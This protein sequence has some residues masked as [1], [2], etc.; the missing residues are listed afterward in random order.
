[1]I[2]LEYLCVE[3]YNIYMQI[4]GGGLSAGIKQ[5]FFRSFADHNL[6]FTSLGHGCGNAFM[7]DGVLLYVE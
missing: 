7:G 1:M 2:L 5:R 3:I 4:I 6:S